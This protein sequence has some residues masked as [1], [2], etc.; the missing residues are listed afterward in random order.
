MTNQRTV[1]S[2]VSCAYWCVV[3]S[4]L[5]VLPAGC[6]TNQPAAP[7]AAYYYLN[8]DKTLT[9]VGRVAIV[10]M[11]NKSS[12]PDVSADVTTALFQALQ[13]RQVFG[14]T[15][16]NRE[17]PSWRNL[18][19]EGN[20]TYGLD[21]MLSIREALRCDGLLVG[22]ITEFRPFPHMAVGLRLKLLDL[23]DGQLLWALEQV[24][25]SAD[26]TTEKHIKDYFKS[27]KRAGFAPLNEQ[28]AAVSP[29]EFIRFVS[30]EVAETL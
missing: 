22:T 2:F 14:L 15:V 7:S 16:V 26:K 25:D 21:Q 6:R 30:F 27:E 9:A 12:Y 24:W 29:L 1:S 3:L 19:L 17:D 4:P 11:E 28:L 18:Q 10:E 20:S 13:K 5:A 8:P 23:R